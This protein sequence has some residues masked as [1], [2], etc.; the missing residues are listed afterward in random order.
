ME[1][2]G[3]GHP[4]RLDE[5]LRRA[6]GVPAVRTTRDLLASAPAVRRSRAGRYKAGVGSI[7]DLLAAQTALANAR[8]QEVQSR[9]YWFL[10]MAQLAHAT[11][12]LLP[13][14][15]E[16][17][18]PAGKESAGNSMTTSSRRDAASVACSSLAGLALG[19]ALAASLRREEGRGARGAN[20]F[21]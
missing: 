12:A 8:A 10:A 21:R 17:V 4:P 20:R 15:T 14:A 11:G 3:P 13:R 19:A 9:S 5:L 1:N 6:D 18:S 16:I 7:L 2:A